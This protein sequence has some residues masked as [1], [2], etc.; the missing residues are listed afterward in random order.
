MAL[1]A[2]PRML[3]AGICDGRLALTHIRSAQG[4]AQGPGPKVHQLAVNV[5]GLDA[6]LEA[7]VGAHCPHQPVDAGG[8]AQVQR[9]AE[10][11]LGVLA[12]LM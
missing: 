3:S 5:E 6:A 2:V 10:G 4:A 7:A 9:G 11:D 1:A 12:L 8:P